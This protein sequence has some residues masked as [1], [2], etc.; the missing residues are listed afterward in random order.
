MRYAD[1]TPTN[2]AEKVKM[3]ERTKVTAEMLEYYLGGDNTNA[4]AWE[5]LLDILND[6][7]PLEDA[8]AE[9]INHWEDQ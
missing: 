2:E 4:E 8:L 9:V 5:M 7:W 3:G 1:D 6:Q